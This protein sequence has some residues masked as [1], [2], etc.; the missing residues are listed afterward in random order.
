MRLGNLQLKNNLVLAPMSGVTDYP[1]RQLAR[2]MGCGLAFT[3][4]VSAEGLIRKGEA[5]LKIKKGEHPVSVQLFGSEPEVSGQA[6][7]MAGAMGSGVIYLTIG[8]AG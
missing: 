4:M 6:A 3:E 8:F 5:F 7:G 2:E 1:F